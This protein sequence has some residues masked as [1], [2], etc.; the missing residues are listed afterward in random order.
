[1]RE[2]DGPRANMGRCPQLRTRTSWQDPAGDGDGSRGHGPL[3]PRPASLPALMYRIPSNLDLSP[4]VGEF[5]TQVRVGQFDLQFT[6]GSVNF[7][8]QSPVQLLRDDEPIATWERGPVA[9]PRLLRHHEHRRVSQRDR[10]R[11]P[12]RDRVRQRPHDA[13][14][15]RLGPIRVLAH[16]DRRTPLGHLRTAH[17]SACAMNQRRARIEAFRV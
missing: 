16:H 12:H 4:V 15:R 7:A 13:T 3:R 6:F 1:M 11:S 8:A 14:R 17:K 5:T 2:S 10:Q 9:R